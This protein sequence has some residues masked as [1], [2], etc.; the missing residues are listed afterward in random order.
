MEKRNSK[1]H[2]EQVRKDKFFFQSAE[3]HND[4]IFW[5]RNRLLHVL[6]C[7]LCYLFMWQKFPTSIKGKTL[8]TFGIERLYLGRFKKSVS[9]EL[10]IFDPAHHWSFML[11]LLFLNKLS[12][13]YPSINMI[14]LVTRAERRSKLD[15]D[16]KGNK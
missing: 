4:Y 2:L 11:F 8:Y 16:G 5:V 3:F 15:K 6:Y 10:V 9:S 7:L 13:L 14:I 1:K 12:P